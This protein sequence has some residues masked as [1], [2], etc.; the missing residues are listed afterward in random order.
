MKTKAKL[1]LALSVLTAGTAFAGATGTFAWFSTNR[2]ATLTYSKVTA[3]SSNSKL[4]VGIG[5]LTDSGIQEVTNVAADGTYSSAISSTVSSGS[6]TSDVSSIDGK[7]FFKPNWVSTAGND[8]AVRE[9]KNV[10]NATWDTNLSN[11]GYY[12][13]YYFFIEN[14]GASSVYVFLDEN[15][16]I[17]TNSTDST[18]DQGKKDTA[19]AKWSRVA[20]IDSGT[21]KP[22]G[23]GLTTGTTKLI[24]E[25]EDSGSTKDKGI[26]STTLTDDSKATISS[27]TTKKGD[28]SSISNSSKITSDQYLTVLESGD[29]EY[30]TVSV[31]LEGT[32]AANQDAAIGGAIDVVLGLTGVESVGA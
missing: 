13:Q 31:W 21:S 17:K 6:F 9:V 7:S 15:T 32:E 2:T 4:K 11:G 14:T 23:T 1:V 16:K 29:K 24:F 25:Q 8:A 20:I 12:T 18:S 22:S 26:G 10:T 28:F 5:G 27:V 19:L 3:V 30:Y